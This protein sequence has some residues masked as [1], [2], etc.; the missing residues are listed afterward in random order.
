MSNWPSPDADPDLMPANPRND[1]N[2]E[3]VGVHSLR[4][5]GQPDRR[6]VIGPDPGE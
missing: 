3:R 6:Q 2:G 1:L 5:D 4:V